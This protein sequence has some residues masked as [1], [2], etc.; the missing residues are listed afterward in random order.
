MTSSTS[1]R[2]LLRR[3]L[4]WAGL[5]ALASWTMG[6]GAMGQVSDGTPN[7]KSQLENG[8]KARFPAE[9]A[10]IHTVVTMVE[11]NQLPLDLVQSTF[12]WVRKNKYH[13]KY[14][15]PYFERLLRSRAAERGIT[16]P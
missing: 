8:L 9:F 10:F 1:G 16:I 13:K 5:G 3:Q 4:L 6:R 14:M 11:N 15:V 2:L 12:L 7:L